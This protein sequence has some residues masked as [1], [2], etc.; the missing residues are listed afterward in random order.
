LILK[1]SVRLRLRDILEAI[2]GIEQTT[3]GMAFGE[4]EQSWQVRRA[5]ERGVE[6][7]SE[8]SRHVSDEMKLR[9]PHISWREIAGIGNLLRHEYGRIDNRIMWRA[10]QKY[11]P[12]LKA[13]VLDMLDLQGPRKPRP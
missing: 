10:V 11:L 2:E 6:I 13:V 4:Y 9:Y 5:V 3:A 1:R 7:I 12:E 8:A